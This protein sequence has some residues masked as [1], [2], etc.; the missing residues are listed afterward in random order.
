[1]KR[2]SN[3]AAAVNAAFE[4][5]LGEF[6]AARDVD[7]R[8]SA[9]HVAAWRQVCRRLSETAEQAAFL[10][11]SINR[12]I[13]RSPS[14]SLSIALLSYADDAAFDQFACEELTR[15]LTN[16]P[17]QTDRPYNRFVN[18]LNRSRR[19]KEELPVL[20][21]G[22]IAT[23]LV[24]ELRNL[25]VLRAQNLF[26]PRLAV[27]QLARDVASLAADLRGEAS[28]EQLSQFIS[29]ASDLVA[30]NRSP[31]FIGDAHQWLAELPA[32]PDHEP[33]LSRRLA[34]SAQAESLRPDSE[35]IRAA[36][37]QLASR[38]AETIQKKPN[39]PGEYPQALESLSREHDLLR[40]AAPVDAPIHAAAEQARQRL[41]QWA[42]G[43]EPSREELAYQSSAQEQDQNLQRLAEEQK[44]LQQETS[45]AKPADAA[46]L[47]ERQSALNQPSVSPA[48]LH[49]AQSL[50]QAESELAKLSQRIGD[51]S[52]S[53]AQWRDAAARADAARKNLEQSTAD[54][55]LPALDAAVAARRQRQEA[56]DK[57]NDAAEALPSSALEQ[58]AKRLGQSAPH[59]A[60]LAETLEDHA[61][62]ARDSDAQ[63]ESRAA[64]QAG[65][66]VAQ[67]QREIVQMRRS[68]EQ[69]DPLTAAR[70]AS[71]SA[72][73]ALRADP[74]D[75]QS[76]VHHQQQVIDALHRAADLAAHRHAA[77]QIAQL[78][79]LAPVL[80]GL[81]PAAA[82]PQVPLPQ[83]TVEWRTLARKSDSPVTATENQAVPPGYQESVRLYFQALNADARP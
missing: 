35:L 6:N 17:A 7:P 67:A 1:L 33:F 24:S 19:L 50:Q 49:L 47:A 57:L 34:A 79:S 18:A 64:E 28:P 83:N 61:A 58:I 70:V 11:L 68:L 77:A 2:A 44:K 27:E 81:A 43:T 3:L 52:R 72:E 40:R 63:A 8:N 54:Q 46:K 51:L 75:L 80:S 13:A 5:A 31:D 76:A 39:P 9:R 55:Y 56:W 73:Q 71:V 42:E 45:Q 32:A 74:P 15:V 23:S 20:A 12:V 62:A 16:P 22:Q 59:L 66:T 41:R 48:R 82:S 60:A 26:R 36:D 30:S 53:A 37:L 14:S 38:A 29:R 65:Q 25:T 4:Q 69:R 78:P 10:R 21:R